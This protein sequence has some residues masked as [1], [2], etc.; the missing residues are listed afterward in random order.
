M[1]SQGPIHFKAPPL[2]SEPSNP[3]NLESSSGVKF[4]EL[5]IYIYIKGQA[6][7]KCQSNIHGG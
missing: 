6:H 2:Y 4:F 3:E 7:P 1:E 5:Y